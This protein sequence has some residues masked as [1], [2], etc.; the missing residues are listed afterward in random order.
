MGTVATDVG[1][2]RVTDRVGRVTRSHATADG[3]LIGGA[4]QRR[5]IAISERRARDKRLGS[6]G[7]AVLTGSARVPAVTL[8]TL[9]SLR[10]LSAIL[11]VL[12]KAGSA[13]SAI[14]AVGP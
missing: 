4:G 13:V 7:L 9:P 14:G 2:I 10:T 12:G 8:V 1:R 3:K 11:A 6:A 5:R